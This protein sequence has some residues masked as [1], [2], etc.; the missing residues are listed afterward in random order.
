M[1]ANKKSR[2]WIIILLIFVLGLGF[3]FF[4]YRN[5]VLKTEELNKK[6]ETLKRDIEVKSRIANRLTQYKT[7]LSDMKEA[8]SK[9]SGYLAKTTEISDYL[10]E[11]GNI[12][13][14]YH[15]TPIAF[16]PGEE[17]FENGKVYGT[18]PVTLEIK[19]D[20]FTLIKVLDNFENGD[21]LVYVNQINVVSSEK[22]K[23]DAQI[24]LS[25]LLQK[26]GVKF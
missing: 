16:Q 21:K 15:I 8:F 19:S 4:V 11:I 7:E 1:G 2:L 9:F 20:Y 18:F 25:L 12:L 6:V 13:S 3:Y 26:E 5:I 22:D 23:I 17:K 10:V 24:K 14:S